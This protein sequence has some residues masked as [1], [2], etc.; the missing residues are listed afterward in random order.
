MTSHTPIDRDH[1]L[2][3]L[4]QDPHVTIV[5]ALP[6]ASYDEAHLPGALN[7]PHDSDEAAI[8]TLLPDRDRTV[9]VYCSNVACQ[10][11]TV[12]SRRLVRLGFSD[13]RD[14]EAGKQDWIDAGLPTESAV[15]V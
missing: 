14:Y 3:L 7:L 11:S 8:V 15:N 12:L 9:V 13:V 10:N 5:E 4:D 6:E 2:E 1:L